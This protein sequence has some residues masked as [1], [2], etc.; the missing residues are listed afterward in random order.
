MQGIYAK[1]QHIVLIADSIDQL[2]SWRGP[3]VKFICAP[4]QIDP[5]SIAQVQREMVLEFGSAAVI[6]AARR[7]HM[8]HLGRN[9]PPSLCSIHTHV[10]EFDQTDV[11]VFIDAQFELSPV[12]PLWIRAALDAAIPGSQSRVLQLASVGGQSLPFGSSMASSVASPLPPTYLHMMLVSSCSAWSGA[13]ALSVGLWRTLQPA[14]EDASGS[15]RSLCM[16]GD[17]HALH[18]NLGATMTLAGRVGSRETRLLPFWRGELHLLDLSEQSKSIYSPATLPMEPNADPSL[19]S[20]QLADTMLGLAGS[21][22][23]PFVGL[24]MLNSAFL[25]MTLHWLCQ[26]RGMQGVLAR[27]VLVCTDAACLD[28]LRS[29]PAAAAVGAIVGVPMDLRLEATRARLGMGRFKGTFLQ[30]LDWGT[31]DYH[32]L[33]LTRQMLLRDL[34]QAGVPFLMMETDA[35]WRKNA[36]EYLDRVLASKGALQHREHVGLHFNVHELN[37]NTAPFD[38]LLY[39]DVPKPR[40]PE[41]IGVGGG[42]FLAIPTSTTCRLFERWAQAVLGSIQESMAYKNAG[43][44]PTEQELL[45]HLL[46]EKAEGVR[47]ELLPVD[48]F[49]SGQVYGTV[50]SASALHA[51]LAKSDAVVIQFNYVIGTGVK[52]ERAKQF[53]HWGLNADGTCGPLPHL[54]S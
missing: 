31:V 46:F 54:P 18:L 20:V 39:V 23:V 37:A 6:L 8:R 16:A 41:L 5:Q 2:R 36:Y 13:F 11:L 26:V 19:G 34:A 44:N 42:F 38:M 15:L 10:S 25:Q 28:E 52:I 49:P 29:H 3:P 32:L 33:M 24:V 53:G 9:W 27:T 7:R 30:G 50:S 22:G 17:W 1:K 40:K 48:L 4:R 45:Q 21:L 14:W 47:A 43:V 51:K 35:W 12:A